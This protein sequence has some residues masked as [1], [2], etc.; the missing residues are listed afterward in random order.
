[1]K[2][3][4]IT[5]VAGV[6]ILLAVQYTPNSTDYIVPQKTMEVVEV[7]PI[8]EIDVIDAAQK[9]LDKI[10]T[11]LDAEETRILEEQTELGTKHESD[12]AELE[13]QIAELKEAYKAKDNALENRLETIRETRMSFQ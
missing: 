12:L 5:A 3:I 2:A 11:Q 4:I 7:E 6:G 13:R 9:E 1:M 8:V 10:N